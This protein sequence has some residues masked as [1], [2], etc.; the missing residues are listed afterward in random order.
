MGRQHGAVTRV[1]SIQTLSDAHRRTI[2]RWAAVCADRVLPLFDG[3]AAAR[4]QLDDALARTQAYSEGRSSAADE[5]RKRLIAGSAAQQ[6]ASSAGAAAARSVG[7]AAAVAHMGAHALGAAGYAAKAVSLARADDA[8]AVQDEIVWQL[9]QLTDE[10]R[11]ILS[12]LPALGA[13]SAGPLGPG[14]LA[15]GIV[16]STI[17][18]IQHHVGAA[19]EPK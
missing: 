9:A 4:G 17:R 11:A 16:G 13:D 3:D 2:A 7:Q 6:A 18:Q 15:R 1:P 19:G 5:I 10:E 12:S 8:S 14:L